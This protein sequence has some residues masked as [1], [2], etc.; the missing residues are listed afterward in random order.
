MVMTVCKCCER[1]LPGETKFCPYC[2]EQV[3]ETNKSNVEILTG[4]NSK[5][6]TNAVKK[7]SGNGS[8]SKNILVI[9]WGWVVWAYAFLWKHFWLWLIIVALLFGNYKKYNQSSYTPSNNSYSSS[10]SYTPSAST[11]SYSGSSSSDTFV[12]DGYYH[13]SDYDHN[14]ADLLKPADSE[15]QSIEDERATLSTRSDELDS[16]MTEMNGMGVNNDSPQYLIDSY[17]EKVE[18]YNAKKTSY[19]NDLQEFNNRVDAYNASN[20]AYNNYLEAHC[21]K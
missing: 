5:D 13:C 21:R 18:A 9:L 11:A 1:E 2:R 17:N 8:K 7:Q 15:K 19:K 20:N 12:H 10:S 16:L 14:Q 4:T 3:V 6:Q